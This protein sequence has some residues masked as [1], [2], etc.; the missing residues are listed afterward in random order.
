MK[1]CKWCH[2]ENPQFAN[3]HIIPKAFFVHD[4]K[5]DRKI[6]SVGEYPRR[7]PTG[8][9]DTNILCV[10]CEKNFQQI[11][12]QAATILLQN[13][14]KYLIPFNDKKD[15]IALQIDGQHKQAI[16]RFLIY[17]LWRASVSTLREFRMIKLGAYEDKIKDALINDKEFGNHEYSF[18]AFKV[19]K[20][21]GNIYP[22]KLNKRAFSGCN[23]YELDFANF[24]FNIKVDSRITPEPLK[25][26]TEYEHLVFNKIYETPEKR[27]QAMV[28]IV[29][30]QK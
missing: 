29:K 7:K 14:D 21:S 12:S 8:S 28:K 22:R 1:H 11:D 5:N 20:S 10:D 16:K 3:S 19:E 17:V 6:L 9:K 4:G 18:S 24:I 23:F 26:L 15:D 30:S 27:R 13:F 2:K 25:S